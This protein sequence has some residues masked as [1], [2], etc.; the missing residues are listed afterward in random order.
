MRPCHTSDYCSGSVYLWCT[1]P[2]LFGRSNLRGQRQR[3]QPIVVNGTSATPFRVRPNL[4]GEAK[5]IGTAMAVF[6]NTNRNPTCPCLGLLYW[7]LMTPKVSLPKVVLGKANLG[8]LNALKNSPRISRNILSVNSTFLEMPRL[9]Y[10]C[11]GCGVEKGPEPGVWSA[12]KC[13]SFAEVRRVVDRQWWSALWM[14][15]QHVSCSAVRALDYVREYHD[16]A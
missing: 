14:F 2:V 16:F 5:H 6:Q 10:E 15:R 8:V 12:T 7:L 11:P 1:L 13:V 4:P 9:Y 3:K